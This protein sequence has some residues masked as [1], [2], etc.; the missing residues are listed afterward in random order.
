LEHA[1]EGEHERHNRNEPGGVR[2]LAA[3]EHNAGIYLQKE[4]VGIHCVF[5]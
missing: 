4:G 5:T 3:L 1:D 2:V